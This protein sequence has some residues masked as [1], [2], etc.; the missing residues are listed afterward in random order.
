[1]QL[2]HYR[3]IKKEVKRLFRKYTLQTDFWDLVYFAE[4]I[5]SYLVGSRG[6]I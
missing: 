4:C 6:D 1:M 5:Y 2:P 3:E